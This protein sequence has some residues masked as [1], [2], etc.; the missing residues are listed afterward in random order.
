MLSFKLNHAWPAPS[1]MLHEAPPAAGPTG[2]TGRA[3]PELHGAV[4]SGTAGRVP[5]RDHTGP[6]AGCGS[7]ASLSV[8]AISTLLAS[9][10]AAGPAGARWPRAGPPGGGQAD[11]E[12][13]VRDSAR[14]LVTVTRML[15]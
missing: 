14:G 4:R 3:G 11:S 13:P 1:S 2:T 10:P 8:D 12:L 15:T 6:R 9:P 7:Y 5:S